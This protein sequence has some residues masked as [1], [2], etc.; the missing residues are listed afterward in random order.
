MDFCFL[1]WYMA[2][3]CPNMFCLRMNFDIYDI[4]FYLFTADY[5][6]IKGHPYP[7]NLWNNV[8]Q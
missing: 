1:V 4:T 8:L 2:K 3:N 6:V 5:F 7:Q